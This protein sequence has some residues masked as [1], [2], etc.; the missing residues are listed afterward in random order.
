MGSPINSIRR[1]F[2]IPI[3]LKLHQSF[4]IPVPKEVRRL[5]DLFGWSCRTPFNKVFEHRSVKR[6]LLFSQTIKPWILK[7]GYFFIR[8]RTSDNY[9]CLGLHAYIFGGSFYKNGFSSNCMSCTSSF[10]DSNSSLIFSSFYLEKSL[11][12]L[13]YKLF[14]LKTNI[15]VTLHNILLLVIGNYIDFISELSSALSYRYSGRLTANQFEFG[16][17]VVVCILFFPYPSL[18]CSWLAKIVEFSKQARAAFSFINEAFSN[19]DPFKC[20]LSGFVVVA[21]GRING[22]DKSIKQAFRWGKMPSETTRA[23]VVTSFI[24]AF[25]SYGVVGI[26]VK[27]YFLKDLLFLSKF[28]KILPMFFTT[29]ASLLNFP[30][31]TTPATKPSV[32][33]SLIVEF[34]IFEF[35]RT[36]QFALLR[37]QIWPKPT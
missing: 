37:H 8:L 36:L 35:W 3:R 7:R 15:C 23:G 14:C 4:F 18:F 24:P 16:V 6:N 21:K 29:F 19:F 12:C 9:F 17:N 13:Y 2:G 33:L 22:S 30:I 11:E 26:R 31:K 1:R 5:V 10:V 32:K 20:K 34:D 28:D 25:T 27:L